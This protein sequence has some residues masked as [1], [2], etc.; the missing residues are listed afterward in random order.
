MTQQYKSEIKQKESKSSSPFE[1]KSQSLVKNIFISPI[2]DPI[3]FLNNFKNTI[4]DVNLPITPELNEF[5]YQ[6]IDNI[7][8]IWTAIEALAETNLLEN[9]LA[10]LTQH[11]TPQICIALKILCLEKSL[12]QEIFDFIIN[13][14]HRIPKLDQALKNFQDTKLLNKPNIKKLI[15]HIDKVVPIFSIINQLHKNNL[16]L[17]ETIFNSMLDAETKQLFYARKFISI[18]GTSLKQNDI[19]ILKYPRYSATFIEAIS[20]LKHKNILSTRLLTVLM[21]RNLNFGLFSESIIYLAKIP[22]VFN[23]SQM[24]K[25]LQNP[26][27]FWI[28]R[29]LIYLEKSGILNKEN[30]DFLMTSATESLKIFKII[31]YA[32]EFEFL[33]QGNFSLLISASKDQDFI[34]CLETLVDYKILNNS[35]YYLLLDNQE[36]ATRLTY[37][38]C[39]L[40]DH[41]LLDPIHIETIMQYTLEYAFVIAQI[42]QIGILDRA[43][44]LWLLSGQIKI[45]DLY[46]QVC[47]LKAHGILDPDNFNRLIEVPSQATIITKLLYNLN[48]ADILDQESF[49]LLMDNL[50]YLNQISDSIAFITNHHCLYKIHLQ[51]LVVAQPAPEVIRSLLA[52][53]E[54]YNLIDAIVLIKIFENIEHFEQ[55]QLG[56]SSLTDANLLNEANFL[57]LLMNVRQGKNFTDMLEHLFKNNILTQNNFDT[58]IRFFDH[59]AM[60]YIIA[61]L[62]KNPVLTQR[63][64]DA[65]I[66]SLVVDSQNQIHASHKSQPYSAATLLGNSLSTVLTQA[67]SEETH[68]TLTT[69]KGQI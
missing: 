18:C 2:A 39:K 26:Y 35:L 45:I 52:Q 16:V 66:Q 31:K 11:W 17:S 69:S 43:S 28:A 57:K 62:E 60:I 50:N 42:R 12:D 54:K 27:A 23:E 9:N 19:E 58:L 5:L 32:F 36:E 68:A 40:H 13:H 29:S 25:F 55:L 14:A 24:Y 8:P 4:S 22:H 37:L 46:P 7:E 53:L 21:A 3:V 49:T 34:Y 65:L 44:F 63:K 30:F 41:D 51:Q 59:P 64:F 15:K 20:C 67:A 33:T 61:Y 38:L 48:E 1:S 47:T 6:N 10:I 56:I